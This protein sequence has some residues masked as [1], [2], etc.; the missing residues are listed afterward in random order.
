VVVGTNRFGF[1]RRLIGFG[2]VYTMDLFL[3]HAERD[4]D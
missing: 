4:D 1:L 3:D 2:G